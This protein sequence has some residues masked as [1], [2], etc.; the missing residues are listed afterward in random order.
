LR[1]DCRPSVS[2]ESCYG[3]DS[4]IPSNI[5]GLKVRASVHVSCAFVYGGDE[6]EDDVSFRLRRIASVFMVI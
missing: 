3:K 1:A 6:E 2:A 4:Y 5:E